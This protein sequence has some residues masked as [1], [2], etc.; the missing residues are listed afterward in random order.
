M[1]V[2]MVIFIVLVYICIGSALGG[3]Y[4]YLR[5]KENYDDLE[6]MSYLP[7]WIA[8]LWIVVAPPAFA[9]LYAKIKAEKTDN[10]D[11]VN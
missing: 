8:I 6:D 3:H 5:H 2:L 7:V 9:I 11:Q 1:K 4:Y 10:K